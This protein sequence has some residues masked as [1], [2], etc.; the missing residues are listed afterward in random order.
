MTR[1][2]KELTPLQYLVILE[3]FFTRDTIQKFQNEIMIHYMDGMS[4]SQTIQLIMRDHPDFN[5]I[6]IEK[7]S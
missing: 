2:R 3:E 4:I 6:E 5:R 7:V 1:T